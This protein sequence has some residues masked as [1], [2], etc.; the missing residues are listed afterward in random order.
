MKKGFTVRNWFAVKVGFT[1]SAGCDVN[2]RIVL[3]NTCKLGLICRGDAYRV[4]LKIK[5]GLKLC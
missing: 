3:R 1:L 5:M 2:I 4:D